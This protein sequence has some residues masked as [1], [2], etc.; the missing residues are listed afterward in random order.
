MRTTVD[1]N[2]KFSGFIADK[3]NKSSSKIC[4]CLPQK[5]VS[6]L[7]AS[8]QPFYDPE[9][10]GTLL[11]E[12][13]R[14]VQ[15]NED[16]QVKMYPYHINDPEFADALVDSFLE[17]CLK[18]PTDCS[19]PQV[20]SSESSQD[21][22]KG[23]DYNVNSSNS[24]TLTYSPSNFPDARPVWVIHEG[25]LSFVEKTLQRTQGILQQLGDQI[26]KGLPIVGAGAGTGISAKFEEAGGVDL[27]V[28]Y[29]SGRFCMAGSGS[30]ACLLPFADANA[31]V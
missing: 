8:G 27:L 1:E 13:K 11:N 26:S 24:G 7:D 28:L 15:I 29:N 20:A 6:A 31:I 14:L 19:L 12:L 30:L 18:N 2:K 10:T 5:G 22:Q 23:H 21:L 4:V 9:A 16:R 3:L 17:I 25:A